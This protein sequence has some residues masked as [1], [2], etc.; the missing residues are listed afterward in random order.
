M[1]H[2]GDLTV[3]ELSSQTNPAPCSPFVADPKRI[4]ALLCAEE[5]SN[6]NNT[7]IQKAIRNARFPFLIT[8]AEFDFTFGTGLRRDLLAPYHGREVVTVTEGRSLSSISAHASTAGR[9]WQGLATS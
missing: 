2:R 4:R 6:R 7:R 3:K 9:P 1:V 5:V 8:I